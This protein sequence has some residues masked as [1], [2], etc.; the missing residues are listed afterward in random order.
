VVFNESLRVR[1]LYKASAADA[2]QVHYEQ[3]SGKDKILLKI[4]WTDLEPWRIFPGSLAIPSTLK[5]FFV[6]EHA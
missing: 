3:K 1:K 6:Q 4:D 5:G 2:L